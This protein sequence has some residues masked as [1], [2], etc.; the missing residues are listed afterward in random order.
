MTIFYQ[1]IDRVR[2]ELFK[3]GVIIY[4]PHVKYV[5]LFIGYEEI[6]IYSFAKVKLS[7]ELF[8]SIDRYM[9][10]DQL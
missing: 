9:V 4:L 5:S 10:I 8:S 1:L 6:T 3:V 7:D 2:F